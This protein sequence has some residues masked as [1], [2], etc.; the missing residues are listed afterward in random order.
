ML[1]SLANRVVQVGREFK[2]DLIHAL[3]DPHATAALLAKQVLESGGHSPV[4]RV[5]TTL[6]GTDITLVGSDPSCSEIVAVLLDQRSDGVTA[7]SQSLA[8]ATHGAVRC[9]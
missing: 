1:L 3:R 2:L 8:A 4:A 5:V 9:A 6:H 7:V